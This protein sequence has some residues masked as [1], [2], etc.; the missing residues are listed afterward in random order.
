MVSWPDRGFK[1][2]RREPERGSVSR[3]NVLQV[4]TLEFILLT[5]SDWQSCSES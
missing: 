1:P 4:H 2:G 5:R 3:S